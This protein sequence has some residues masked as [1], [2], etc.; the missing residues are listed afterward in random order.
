MSD[1][2]LM[3]CTFEK[4]PSPSGWDWLASHAMSTYDCFVVR[5]PK[6]A[7]LSTK[8]DRNNTSNLHT[9]MSRTSRDQLTNDT[10]RHFFPLSRPAPRSH[11]PTEGDSGKIPVQAAI[12]A[13][14]RAVACADQPQNQGTSWRLRSE[15]R[16]LSRRLSRSLSPQFSDVKAV[17]LVA[18]RHAEIASGLD[19]VG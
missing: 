7:L 11:G 13:L 1:Q 9:P 2:H 19:L 5:A 8:N 10:K 4:T 3:V 15:R 6:I 16:A 12:L 18:A 14:R 17:E